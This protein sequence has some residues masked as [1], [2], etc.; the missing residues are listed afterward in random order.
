M[1]TW[2]GAGFADEVDDGEPLEDVLDELLDEVLD[3]LEE[4]VFEVELSKSVVLLVNVH[5]FNGS[6]GLLFPS[7]SSK[8][9]GARV[10]AG[11]SEVSVL[12]PVFV[13]VVS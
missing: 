6:S 4:T 2:L 11:A 5:V 8:D 12:V 13:V 9:S 3:E 1:G 10:H 7:S